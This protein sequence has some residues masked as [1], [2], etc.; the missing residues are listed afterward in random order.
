M[1]IFFFKMATFNFLRWQLPSHPTSLTAYLPPNRS[2]YPI[3]FSSK[4][5]QRV[6]FRLPRW[7][8]SL[9]FWFWG[10]REK[11]SRGLVTTPLGGWGLSANIQQNSCSRRSD[12]SLQNTNGKKYQWQRIVIIPT[13]QS[14]GN[15]EL[16]TNLPIHSL[17]KILNNNIQLKEH[18]TEFKYNERVYVYI[19]INQRKYSQIS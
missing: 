17:N 7:L 2:Q 6:Y 1:N 5:P 8:R 10:D 3:F 9:S 18:D 15:V 4:W 11:T 14:S 16:M 12:T 13:Q 19:N